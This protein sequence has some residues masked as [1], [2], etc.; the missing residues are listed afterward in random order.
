MVARN[1]M[2]AEELLGYEVPGK[3]VELR[4]GQL[5]IRE[6]SSFHHGEL[7]LRIGVALT[8]HLMTEREGW[9]ITRGRVATADPGFTIARSPDT[10]RAPDVAYLSRERFP[11]RLPVGFP[12]LA[13]D[14][15]IEIRSP[16][17][18]PGELLAKVADWISAGAQLVWVLDAAREAVTVYRADGTVTVLRGADVIDGEMV[19]PGFLLALT[20]LFAPG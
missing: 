8:N 2:T 17:D 9:A 16:N 14:L 18:R 3:R 12:E 20:V 15:A 11:E 5:L 10:V 7:T 6:P 19:L 4:R 13:P 1:D